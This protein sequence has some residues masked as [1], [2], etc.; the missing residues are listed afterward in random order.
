MLQKKLKYVKKNNAYIFKVLYKLYG[1]VGVKESG[2]LKIN[3]EKNMY[4]V[5]I[6]L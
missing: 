1:G 2:H 6:C 5:Y 3:I 4:V